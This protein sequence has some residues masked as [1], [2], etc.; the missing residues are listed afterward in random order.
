M[1]RYFDNIDTQ[2]QCFHTMS[3]HNL[4]FRCLFKVCHVHF[5]KYLLPMGVYAYLYSSLMRSSTVPRLTLPQ[6][7]FMLHDFLR[8]KT[9]FQEF[10]RHPSYDG[11][12]RER[13][14][15]HGTGSHNA[16]TTDGHPFQDGDIRSAPHIV[17]Y[18][19]RQVV[20][21]EFLLYSDIDDIL[22]DKVRPV[23]AGDDGGTRPENHL[24]SDGQ[25]SV[26][27]IERGP[28]GDGSAVTDR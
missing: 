25:E 2:L 17:L 4:S 24:P 28:F 26:C 10:C 27:A 1:R 9:H 12:G 19:H 6:H 3:D 22:P 23:V 18:H 5:R 16:A 8:C 11:I 14:C 20:S 13:V 21:R 15:H 7:P